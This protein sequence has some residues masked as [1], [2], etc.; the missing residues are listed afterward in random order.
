MDSQ[1]FVESQALN[2]TQFTKLRNELA[3]SKDMIN[4][5][6]QR[7]GRQ[8]EKIEACRVG[9]DRGRVL[10]QERFDEWFANIGAEQKRL[11]RCVNDL[12]QAQK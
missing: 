4:K 1:R 5:Q 3:M 2:E 10:M 6:T 9:V 11:Q 7:N 8:D 12:E